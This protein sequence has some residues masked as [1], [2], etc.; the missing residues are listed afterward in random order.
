MTLQE[1]KRK[2]AAIAV[3]TM[4]ALQQKNNQVEEDSRW[5]LMG[6]Y[7]ATQARNAPHLYGRGFGTYNW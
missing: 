1:K 3:A 2:A 5:R 7:R 4:I 6:L